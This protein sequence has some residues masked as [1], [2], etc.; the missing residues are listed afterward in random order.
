MEKVINHRA[1][2]VM[3]GCCLLMAMGYGV[4][5]TCVSVFV[6]PVTDSLGISRTAMMM[7]FTLLSIGAMCFKPFVSRTLKKLGTRFVISLTIIIQALVLALMSTF[8]QAW[9][10]QMAGLIIGPMLPFAMVSTAILITNWF[11][12]A[13]GTALGIAMASSGI[14]GCI[15]A[16]IMTTFI[17]RY[18]WEKAFLILAVIVLVFALPF[19]TTILHYHPGEVGLLPYGTALHGLQNA[20]YTAEETYEGAGL[21]LK[22]AK[23]HVSFYLLLLVSLLFGFML[24]LSSNAAAMVGDAGFAPL[25]VGMVVSTQM[26]GLT[27][28]KIALG[29]IKDKWNS[30]LSTISSMLCFCAGVILYM[31][32]ITERSVTI[33]Y[34]AAAFA[35]FGLACGT[36]LP[37]LLTKEAMG[38]KDYGTM[39]GYATMFQSLGS[40][41]GF[42]ILGL[43]YDLTGDYKAALIILAIISLTAIPLSLWAT[44]KGK[45]VWV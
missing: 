37:P 22:E 10:F 30:D 41:L 27:I 7:Y 44:R 28:G 4:S 43:M 14:C 2:L 38:S 23:I 24:S 9:Q 42:F 15:L 6:K 21:T 40:A 29:A 12:K 25:A 20:G 39:V 45:A 32:A 1:W 36:V 17:D 19:T 26:I 18:G 34:L 16:P 5:T 11:E 35:G 33:V 8:S 3:V 31:F 13:T